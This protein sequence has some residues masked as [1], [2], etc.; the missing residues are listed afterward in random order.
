LNIYQAC[1]VPAIFFQGKQVMIQHHYEKNKK[2]GKIMLSAVCYQ[3]KL[4]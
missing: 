4:S 1:D 3:M 2:Y